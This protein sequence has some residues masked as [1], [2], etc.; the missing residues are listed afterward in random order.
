MLP[1]V[2][3]VGRPN[4]G[5]SSLFNM[6]TRRTVSIVDPTAG[7]TRD[8]VS[9]VAELPSKQPGGDPIYVE[10][11]DTGGYGVE[12][13][14][15]KSLSA[16]VEKQIAFGLAEAHVIMFVVDAQTG[17]TPLDEQIGRL[18][19]SGGGPAKDTGEPG[20]L[21]KRVLL[22]ANKVDSPKHEADAYEASGL[23]FGEPLMV[24]A[25][26]GHHRY[27]L[28]E[29]IRGRIQEAK[30][31]V[32]DADE[33]R[34]AFDETQL[35]ETGPLL[36]IVGKRNAGKSTFVNALAG[37][38]RVIVSELE[39]T[40][41]DSVDVLFEIDGQLFTAI[42]TAGVRKRKSLDGSLEYYS[43]HRSL[44][45]V[46]RADVVLF[47]IDSTVPLSQVDKQLH[48]EIAKHHKPVIFVINKWDLVEAEHDQDE[49][50]EYLDK[51]LPGLDFVPMAFVSAIN[52]EGVQD[53][54]ELAM[55]LYEQAGHRVG[56]AHLNE[57][58]E[59]IV[60]DRPPKSKLGKQARIY[61]A[62]QVDTFPPTIA[63]SVN[64]PEIFDP[65]YQRYLM[66][67]MRDVLPF[68]EVPINLLIRGKQREGANKSG[69]GGKG[70]GRG[71][72]GGGKRNAN[73][74]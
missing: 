32:T 30:Q 16:E 26:S 48:H 52:S 62:T 13:M 22:V 64:A 53:V 5:K 12:D 49:Y 56:T 1:K 61:Y 25:T 73:K 20:S 11:I 40:T 7:V 63:L 74:R 15:G 19:R 50:M 23:G 65:A 17:L 41:R 58:M 37:S 72:K 4:V 68:S 28:Y 2:V 55:N 70:R 38:E 67:R 27:D 14:A 47:L 71:R 35:P 59:A 9:A 66:N 34:A 6:M 24:S 43:Y 51:E 57:V 8:R 33:A 31:V 36:A 60:A 29:A 21:L 54:I 69:K 44:R 10:L 46:R 42:D 45:S 39:G 18:L 3:V